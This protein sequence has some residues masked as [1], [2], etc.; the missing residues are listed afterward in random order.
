MRRFIYALA[1]L[2]SAF[3]PHAAQAALCPVVQTFTTGQTL[4][5][6]NLNANPIALSNCFANIDYTNI[7]AA[8]LYA[9]NITPGSIGEATFGGS[10]TYTFPSSLVIGGNVTNSGNVDSSQGFYSNLSNGYT[11]NAI[12]YGTGYSTYGNV[13]INS[14][15]SNPV[16]GIYGDLLGLSSNSIYFL[17]FDHSGNLAIAG[18]YYTSGSY[19][20]QT[21][22]MAESG[23]FGTY[24]QAPYFN[25][26]YS[27]T[28]GLYYGGGSNTSQLDF[29]ITNS[30]DWTFTSPL[31]VQGSINQ[32]VSSTN[33]VTPYDAN[34]T[35]GSTNTHIEHWIDNYGSISNGA[36]VT[37]LWTFTKA[38]TSAPG[39]T[40][41]AVFTPS[42]GDSVSVIPTGA[43][44]SSVYLAACNNSVSARTITIWA[45]ASGE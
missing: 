43:S 11:P 16:S 19:N 44:G 8:G 10:Q 32:T 12:T 34:S 33:Y 23:T 38:F 39:V 3:M 18:N 27:S 26:D 14:S 1:F 35:S 36:C 6:T 21:I 17:A 28:Q 7:G 20:G 42:G 22:R 13:Q 45:I 24:I 30:N 15:S 29:N 25:S 4:T 2:F 41:N 40:A 9:S 31:V 5:Q 37:N